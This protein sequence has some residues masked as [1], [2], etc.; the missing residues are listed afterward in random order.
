MNHH[1]T[2]WYDYNGLRAILDVEFF[3]TVGC[4]AT[5]E[6]PAEPPE[7]EVINLEVVEYEGHDAF[8]MSKHVVKILEQFD[9][10]E[11]YE[12]FLQAVDGGEDDDL[13]TQMLSYEDFLDGDN[14]YHSFQEYEPDGKS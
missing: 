14:E 2:I 13:L 11:H 10:K 6:Q 1:T 4:P 5:R 3:V 12:T 7:V 8:E 9:E